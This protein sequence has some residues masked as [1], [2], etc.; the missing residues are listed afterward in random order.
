MTTPRI[1]GTITKGLSGPGLGEDEFEA[2]LITGSVDLEGDVTPAS[3]ATPSSGSVPLLW[4]HRPAAVVGVARYQRVGNRLVIRCTLIPKGTTPEGDLAR[5]CA[6]GDFGLGVSAGFQPTESTPI[7]G[8]SGRTYNKYRLLEAS[9][10]AVPCDQN[11][12]ITAR[13]HN[14][15]LAHRMA[16]LDAVNRAGRL[17]RA[18]ELAAGNVAPP[19]AVSHLTGMSKAAR[20]A[21]ARDLAERGG[22]HVN[23][24]LLG[25][26]EASIRRDAAHA[27]AVSALA[28]MS[29]EARIERA[30]HLARLRRPAGY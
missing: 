19:P 14:A 20:I 11:A 15:D 8:S 25:I 13:A 22:Q 24:Q 30:E 18:R 21:Y 10:V 29:R 12:R 2:D 23:K 27:A 5:V 4:Q 6:K 7:K 1:F 28:P 3:G 16:R 17:Q 9:L 26:R